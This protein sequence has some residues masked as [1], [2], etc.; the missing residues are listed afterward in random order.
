[1]LAGGLNREMRSGMEASTHIKKRQP[2]GLTRTFGRATDSIR[3][4][5]SGVGAAVKGCGVWVRN[6]A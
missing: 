3:A 6:R 5:E 1:M 4:K 2:K